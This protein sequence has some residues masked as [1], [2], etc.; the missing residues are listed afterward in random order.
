MG[1]QTLDLLDKLYRIER[2]KKNYLTFFF[3]KKKKKITLTFNLFS[4][5][6]VESKTEHKQGPIEGFL[7]ARLLC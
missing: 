3:S 6:Q 1:K 5:V 2:R 4:F 7:L